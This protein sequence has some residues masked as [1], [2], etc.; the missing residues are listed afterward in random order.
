MT[1]LLAVALVAL[2]LAA[3]GGGNETSDADTPPPLDTGPAPWPAPTDDVSARIRAAGLPLLEAEGTEVHY[4]AHLD[5]F[6]DGG[7]VTVPGD[8]GIDRKAARISPLHTHRTD[9]IIHVEA[10]EEAT[11]T[12]GQLFTEWGVRLTPDCIGGYCAPAKPFRVVV[13]G[14]ERSGDP[15]T[16]VIEPNQEIAIVIGAPPAQVPATSG[17]EQDWVSTTTSS[18][19]PP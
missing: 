16:V 19:P 11:F 6:L 10:E 9:R 1:R 4:H 12:L 13:N 15:R 17:L 3:C 14:T 7:P 18:T 2:L 5:I 8:I